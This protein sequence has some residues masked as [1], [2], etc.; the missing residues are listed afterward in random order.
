MKKNEYISIRVLV[1]DDQLAEVTMKLRGALSDFMSAESTFPN[2]AL[3]TEESTPLIL[4]GLCS[5]QVSMTFV[6]NK[7]VDA[8]PVKR[9][10]ENGDF[11]GIFDLVLLDDRWPDGETAG[12]DILLETVDRNIKGI[13][14]EFPIISFFTRSL[15]KTRL[16]AFYEVVPKKIANW[17][18]VLPREKSD[19]IQFIDLLQRTIAAKRITE[20][21]ER[22]EQENKILRERVAHNSTLAHS[23][24]GLLDHVRHLV[25]VGNILLELADVL[26]PFFQW[27]KKEYLILPKPLQQEFVSAILLEGEPGS[28][29]T[30]VCRAIANAFGGA[31][32]L[33]K[34][35][36]PFEVQG[37]WQE[38]FNTMV[39]TIYEGALQE[40]VVVVQADD[41]VWPSATQIMDGGLAAD[42]TAY[43]NTLRECIEDAALINSGESPRGSIVSKIQGQ[44]KGKIVWLLARNRDEE[45]GAMFEPLRQKL[46]AFQVAFPRN[47]DDRRDVLLFHA[48]RNHV[49]FDDKALETVLTLTEAYSG[50]DL[51]GDDTGRRGFLWFAIRKV[52]NRE[53]DRYNQGQTVLHMVITPEVVQ[54]WLESEECKEI[55]RRLNNATNYNKCDGSTNSHPDGVVA[56]LFP[57]PKLR[58]LA[59]AH[60]ETWE[61]ICR[62]YFSN[63]NSISIRDISSKMPSP[64]KGKAHASHPAISDA[65]LNYGAVMIAFLDELPETF[66]L[67]SVYV[68]Q[69]SEKKFNFRVTHFLRFSG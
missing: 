64:K 22:L 16:K 52:K 13:S 40:K 36:G 63:K 6:C 37:K 15:D 11:N 1:L 42:W 57:D 26:E 8:A 30:T 9:R 20:D 33:P 46:M 53:L 17:E 65:C 23:S 59:R 45:V 43:L 61:D 41:L 67:L 7:E 24:Y 3:L 31:T 29:K 32:I 54:D 68:Q 35:L 62:R 60:L 44:F 69:K 55:K 2:L 25:G 47:T 49:T 14:N 28:G 18:R 12:R 10:V 4:E 34:N 58:G 50:R 21:R 27:A 56:K 51:I 66:A 5:L 38:P 39:R 19:E 48:Q